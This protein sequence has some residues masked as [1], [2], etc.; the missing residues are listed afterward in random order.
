MNKP[1]SKHPGTSTAPPAAQP[2]LSREYID[3]SLG[4]ALAH[5]TVAARKLFVTHIQEATNLRPVEFSLLLLLLGNEDVTPKALC[6]ALAVPASNLTPI[7]DRLIE[8]G[9]V[10]RA[11]S[12]HDGRSQLIE[13]TPKG[14]KLAHRV[15][16]ISLSM[17]D[18]LLAPLTAVER[19]TLIS[20]LHR[21]A[22][23]R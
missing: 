16:E 7:V 15:H 23:E 12:S 21:L 14:R 10:R 8:Q 18:G 13:L 22:I 6:R 4:F 1:I 2:A 17:E 3:H 19:K 5:A 20:M 11:P 9:H